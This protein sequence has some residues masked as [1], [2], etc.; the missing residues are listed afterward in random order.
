MNGIITE[1]GGFSAGGGGFSAITADPLSEA[2]VSFLSTWS[3]DV[4]SFEC[5]FGVLL[6]TSIDV[7]GGVWDLLS[8]T[9]LPTSFGTLDMIVNLQ[10]C[11]QPTLIFLQQ[12]CLHKIHLASTQWDVV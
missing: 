1:E 11:L 10:M 8:R 9:E 6:L 7:G 2:I 4:F 3:P 12:T 5:L